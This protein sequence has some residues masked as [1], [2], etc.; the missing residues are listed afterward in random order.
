MDQVNFHLIHTHCRARVRGLG[1]N[2]K[3]NLR[4]LTWFVKWNLSNSSGIVVIVQKTHHKPPNG[5]VIFIAGSRQ[6][7]LF[8]LKM[9]YNLDLAV[10]A[11]H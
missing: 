1:G 2:N 11:N 5:K 3:I 6:N 8:A 7:H 10:F 4:H 9:K